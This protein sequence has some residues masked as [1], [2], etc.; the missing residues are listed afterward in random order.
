M[1]TIEEKEEQE[2]NIKIIDE[3]KQGN[4][5]DIDDI[6]NELIKYGRDQMKN[7]IYELVLEIWRKETIPKEWNMNRLSLS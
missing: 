6:A 4:A 5:G 1:L 7:K 3:L 2:K